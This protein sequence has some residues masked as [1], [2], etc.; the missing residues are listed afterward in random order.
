VHFGLLRKQVLNGLAVH[1][2]G[3]TAINR[4]NGRALGFFVETLALGAFIGR[5]IIDIY[6]YRRKT[7]V[8]AYYRSIHQG[9]IPFD[10][11]SI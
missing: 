9:K 10:G 2:V 8:R 1:L 3:H 7:L 5:D 4:A 11:S 6:T